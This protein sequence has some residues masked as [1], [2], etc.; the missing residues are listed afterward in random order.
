MNNFYIL[1]VVLFCTANI[2]SQDCT[3]SKMF[4]GAGSGT[5]SDPYQVTNV[6]QLQEMKYDLDAHYI[7]IYDIDTSDTEN[8]SNGLGFESI[9]TF[10]Q[11][12]SLEYSDIPTILDKSDYNGDSELDTLY[13]VSVSGY[14]HPKEIRWGSASFT[15]QITSFDYFDYLETIIQGFSYD[16]NEDNIQDIMFII[17]GVKDTNSSEIDT[18]RV[19]C[20]FGDEYSNTITNLNFSNTLTHNFQIFEL[21]STFGLENSV[22]V[23]YS[24]IPSL[25]IPVFDYSS[26]TIDNNQKISF[27]SDRD[28]SFEL[29]LRPNPVENLLYLSIKSK[30][31]LI[32][33]VNLVITDLY[34][35]VVISKQLYIGKTDEK[36]TLDV[37]KLNNGSY[38]LSLQL[39]NEWITKTF[40]IKR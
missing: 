21:S 25:I 33:N 39:N 29:E 13:G 23:D 37:S 27:E 1:L 16:F 18:S 5:E 34:G 19:F 10:S 15:G 17:S 20:F 22:Y 40:I 28:Y 26:E 38:Y 4:S 35:K 12:F 8:W 24:K 3:V 11:S 6:C 30:E 32:N 2:F 7:I 9:I 31:N 14:Y 36:I